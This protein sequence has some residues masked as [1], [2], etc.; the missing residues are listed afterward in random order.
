MQESL[1]ELQW[2]GLG[3]DGVVLGRG[4]AFSG[5]PFGYLIPRSV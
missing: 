1:G 5:N 4:W 3:A 2:A